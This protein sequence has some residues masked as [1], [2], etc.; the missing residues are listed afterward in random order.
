MSFE[1]HSLKGRSS[2]IFVIAFAPSLLRMAGVVPP[3][4]NTVCIYS[5]LAGMEKTLE[6]IL[7]TDPRL[8][9]GGGVRRKFQCSSLDTGYPALNRL[10]HGR[11]WPRGVTSELYLPGQGIG[12]L[13]LLLPALRQLAGVGYGE[14]YI[15]WVAPPYLP[16]APVLARQ[17]VDLRRLL[18]IPA[19]A[20]RDRLWAMEQ[21]LLSECCEAVFGWLGMEVVGLRELRRLQLAAERS[22]C[23]SVLFRHNRCR[24]L[25]S[26]SAL[27]IGLRPEPR[28]R[29]DIEILKQPGGWA[30]QRLTLSVAPH[31]EQ[32]QRLPVELLPAY[33]ANPLPVI[34]AG[35]AGTA[36]PAIVTPVFPPASTTAQP[37]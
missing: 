31:Y 32:W 20:L 16:Y 7:A 6:Q 28:G 22:G 23:W 25:P 2:L 8:W 11:G 37:R 24:S 26:P 17:G 30:G 4:L 10:L 5:I 33:T 13:R 35:T 29:L 12:E 36:D 18:V 19:P 1:Q 15:A 14:G 34:A 21:V 9:R 3:H 27:R